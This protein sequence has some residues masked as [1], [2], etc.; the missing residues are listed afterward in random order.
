MFAGC[1]S[2]FIMNIIWYEQSEYCYFSKSQTFRSTGL[3]SHE[4]HQIKRKCI[5]KRDMTSSEPAIARGI[6]RMISKS[7]V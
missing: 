7:H 3:F 6:P 5:S 1:F 4:S 2:V